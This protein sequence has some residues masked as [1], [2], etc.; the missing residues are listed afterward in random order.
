MHTI[1]EILAET[2]RQTTIEDSM[3][4]LLS[5]LKAQVDAAGGN[6]GKIDAAFAAFKANNDRAAAAIVANTPPAPP[7]QQPG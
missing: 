2:N 4:S 3:E 5:G 6:Q 1:D 7:A